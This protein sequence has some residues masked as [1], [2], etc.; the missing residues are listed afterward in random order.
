[1]TRTDQ[2]ERLVLHPGLL[3]LFT[4]YGAKQGLR[5]S[6]I[7]TGNRDTF[8]ISMQMHC[9]DPRLEIEERPEERELDLED[10]CRKGL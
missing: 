7:F 9:D 10:M 8:P 2:K 3:P 4:G 6:E 1:V 5:K